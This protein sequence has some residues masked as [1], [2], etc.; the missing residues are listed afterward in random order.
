MGLVDLPKL[1]L[2]A[3][4]QPGRWYTVGYGWPS[5][6]GVAAESVIRN[7]LK[8]EGMTHV[9][10]SPDL[11]DDDRAQTFWVRTDR[12]D[13]YVADVTRFGVELGADRMNVFYVPDKYIPPFLINLVGGAQESKEDI[14]KQID[15]GFDLLGFL[16]D[17][18]PMLAV[19]AVVGVAVVVTSRG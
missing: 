5:V 7:K 6:A 12:D 17:Y 19:V 2:A 16:N 11:I 15:K 14:E 1:P 18:G 13:I 8:G 4:L 10:F 3:K 9:V